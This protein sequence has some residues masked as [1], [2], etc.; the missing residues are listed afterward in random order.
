MNFNTLAPVYRAME[1]LCAGSE[2]QTC[3]IACLDS[4]QTAQDILVLGE[5][6]GRFLEVAVIRFPQARFTVID[7]SPA[8]LRRAEQTWQRLAS[9]KGSCVFRATDALNLSFDPETYD[10]IVTPFF[11]DCFTELQLESLIPKL[12]VTLRPGGLWLISDFSIPA[13]GFVRHRARTIHALMY[14]FFHHLIGI[15]AS[16][17]TNPAPALLASGLSR[18]HHQT[19]NHGL[20]VSMVWSKPQKNPLD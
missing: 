2:L 17:W 4:L 18:I 3:R 8:M 15:P 13:Q 1:F 16:L 5:G 11:L 19:F 9:P 20:L 14:A 7:A 6:P 10:S 12:A